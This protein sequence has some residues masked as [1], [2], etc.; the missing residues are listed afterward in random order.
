MKHIFTACL[1][2]LALG[3]SPASAADQRMPTKAPPLAAPPVAP[4]TGC[5]IGVNVGGVWARE[6]YTD[7]LALPPEDALGSH[8]ASG[9]TGGGQLGCDWQSGAWVFGVQG[10]FDGA[11]LKGDHLFDGDVFHTRIPW[12]A[13]GTVR[14][15]Y[16]VD[17]AVLLYVKGGVVFKRQEETIIDAGIVEAAAEKTRTGFLIGGGAE[18]RFWTNWSFFVEGAYLGFDN[19]NIT[20]TAFPEPPATVAGPPFPLRIRENAAVFLAGVN[21]RFAPLLP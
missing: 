18:W 4:W 2:L 19:T 20:F 11:D 3:A 12:W 7:P 6:K 1:A 16:L 13:S 15:G 14:I 5:Y 8:T 10:M 17:P 9:F 21:Y